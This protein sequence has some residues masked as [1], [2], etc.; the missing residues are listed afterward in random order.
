MSDQI[1][2]ISHRRLFLGI[3]E[4]VA[5]GSLTII[6]VVWAATRT[7]DGLAEVSLT[8]LKFSFSFFFLMAGTRF[9]LSIYDRIKGGRAES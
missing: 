2:T 3:A 9:A 1:V 4:W 6:L 8:T 7:V 5:L